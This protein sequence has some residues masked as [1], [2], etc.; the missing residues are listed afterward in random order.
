MRTGR[1]QA[2]R[3]ASAS[4]ALWGRA[5]ARSPATCSP[6]STGQAPRIG[7][8]APSATAR[9]RHPFPERRRPRPPTFPPAT[10]PSGYSPD[11]HHRPEEVTVST[12]ITPELVSLDVGLGADKAAVIRA[13]AARVVEQ[14]RATDAEGLFADAWAR[15]QK[16]ETGLPGG[17]AIPHAK[18]GAVTEPSLA[19]ARLS[20]GVDFGAPDG[21]ADLVF[22]IAAPEGAAE[23]HL[24]VLS[25]LARSLMQDDFTSGLRAAGSADEVVSI[26]RRAIGEEDAATAG[27]AASVAAPVGATAAGATA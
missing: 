5:T 21:P 9:R 20:P 15:E 14:G 2:S 3:R 23:A 24:A 6:I 13:L 17:I 10:Y 18:S 25:K 26:V 16:D 19:F 7:S 12:T 1:G 4:S 11:L 27:A 22:L 8:A